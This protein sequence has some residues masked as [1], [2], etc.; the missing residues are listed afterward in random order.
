[1]GAENWTVSQ[2]G[3]KKS[4]EPFYVQIEKKFT[5]EFKN[6]V[7]LAL[8]G[9][10]T[11][12][13]LASSKHGVHPNQISQWKQP[14]KEQIAAGIAGKSQKAQQNDEARIKEL[15][16]KVGQLTLKKNFLQQAFAKI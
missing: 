8:S 15:H 1:M 9:E 10:Q 5:A 13:E 16:A 7:A 2:G 12:F 14:A 3:R 11:L 6:R 4:Q